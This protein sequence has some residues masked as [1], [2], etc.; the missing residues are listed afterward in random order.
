[1]VNDLP[2]ERTPDL[3]AGTRFAAVRMVL[4][5]VVGPLVVF[6]VAR[7]TGISEVWSLV[8][9][10]VPPAVGVCV[11][12]QRRRRIEVIGVV[13]LSGIAL[14]LVLAVLSNDPKVILLE[15]AAV[16]AVFATAQLMSLRMRRPLVF[17]FA[18]AFQGGRFSA[19]GAEM[20]AEYDRFIEARSFWRLAA[21]VW[22]TVGLME[23]AARVVVIQLV[24]TGT[25]LA[26]NRIVPWLIF[27]GLIAWTYWAG[28]RARDV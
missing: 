3:R 23:A 20:E 17:Y 4:L 1:M 9:S 13:V 6:Q 5:D 26:I 18:Q 14:S 12:W 21:I 28:H 22:G 11:D 10:G 27:A 16:T 19:A 8:L 2:A 24:S 7:R 15:G 25:A